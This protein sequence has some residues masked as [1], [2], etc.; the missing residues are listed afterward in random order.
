ME[1]GGTDLPPHEDIVS[2]L[3]LIVGEVVAV[4]GLHEG[5]EGS[6]LA[7]VFPV[8]LLRGVP[9]AGEEGMTATDDLALKEC[10][11]VRIV[12]QVGGEERV[13]NRS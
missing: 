5:S 4:E 8:H 10:G 3:D 2:A 9:L 6:K 11:E 12:L 7:P 13:T 1:A